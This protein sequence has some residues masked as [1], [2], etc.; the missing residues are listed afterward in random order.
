M[1][2]F[3]V[4]FNI[5]I[6]IAGRKNIAKAKREGKKQCDDKRYNKIT[7]KKEI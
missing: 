1:S 7:E 2:S 5:A 3:H 6:Y 4:Y